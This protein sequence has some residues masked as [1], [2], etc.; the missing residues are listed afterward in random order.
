MR[1][2]EVQA[3]TRPAGMAVEREGF[4]GTWPGM[5]CERLTV[6]TNGRTVGGGVLAV[7][8]TKTVADRA[9]IPERG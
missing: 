1:S 4:F 3:G 6:A 2:A 5:G 7:R 9:P 8:A